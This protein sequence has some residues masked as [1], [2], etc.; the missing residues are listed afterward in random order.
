[1]PTETVEDIVREMLMVAH[2]V[3]ITSKETTLSQWRPAAFLRMVSDR[4]LAA[5]KREIGELQARLDAIVEYADNNN[6]SSGFTKNE[7]INTCQKVHNYDMNKIKCIA[8]GY[9]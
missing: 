8:K 1:M 5:R 3:A 6:W 7:C 4:L 2:N 9:E